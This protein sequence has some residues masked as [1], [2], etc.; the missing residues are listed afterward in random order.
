[1]VLFSEGSLMDIKFA[2]LR[3]GSY[4]DFL[5]LL[6]FFD[7]YYSK[8]SGSIYKKNSSKESGHLLNMYHK[9]YDILKNNIQNTIQIQKE[10]TPTT[11]S[12]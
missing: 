3:E 10:Y 12:N 5:E 8:Y 9:A 2:L 11:I 7:Y 6:V 1:M 4:E